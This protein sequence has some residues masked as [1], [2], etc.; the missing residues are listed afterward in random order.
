MRRNL[1]ICG[2]EVREP[3]RL[4]LSHDHAIK[5]IP[6]PLFIEHNIRDR[7]KGQIANPRSDFML[8]LT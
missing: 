5:R 6:R 8:D 1:I 7:G 4:G 3:I 2:Y